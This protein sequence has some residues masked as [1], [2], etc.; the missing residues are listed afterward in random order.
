MRIGIV[1][2]FNWTGSWSL[3]T[4]KTTMRPEK[5]FTPRQNI[6]SE[7]MRAIARQ[8]TEVECPCLVIGAVSVWHS[9]QLEGVGAGR[10]RIAML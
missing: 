8:G 4:C 2:E 10:G 7:G 3:S 5:E 1:W 9:E 6:F